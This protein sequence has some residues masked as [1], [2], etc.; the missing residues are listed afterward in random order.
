MNSLKKKPSIIILSESWIQCEEEANLFLLPDYKIFVCVGRGNKCSGI[1]VY[2]RTTGFLSVCEVECILDGADSVLLDCKLSN[3]SKFSLLC[4]YRWQGLANIFLDSLLKIFDS[5]QFKNLVVVG[6]VNINLQSD[7]LLVDEYLR[8]ISMYG[9]ESL[10]NISTRIDPISNKGT[11]IDHVLVNIPSFEIGKCSVVET[12]ITDHRATCVSLKLYSLQKSSTRNGYIIDF[13]TLSRLL[14]RVDWSEITQL[15]CVND[16]YDE[17]L[18]KLSDIV[19]L[20]KVDATKIINKQKVKKI[21]PWMTD[22]LCLAVRNKEKMYKRLKRLSGSNGALQKDFSKFKKKVDKWIKEAKARYYSNV[23]DN[24]ANN[25]KKQW[26]VINSLTGRTTHDTKINL[27]VNKSLIIDEK[28][29]SEHFNSYFVQIP[30]VLSSSIEKLEREQVNEYLNKFKKNERVLTQSMFLSPVSYD[31]VLSLI[32]KLEVSKSAGDDNISSK[33]VKMIGSQIAPVLVHIFNKSLETG[34]FPNKMKIAKVIPIHKSGSNTILNNYRPISLLSVFSKLLEK[35]VKKRLLSFLNFHNILS[36]FQFGFR[37]ELNTE[38]ALH[39]FMSNIYSSLNNNKGIKVSGLFLDIQ[40]AFDTVNHNLL[41]EKMGRVGMR[42]NVLNWFKSYLNNRSQYVQIGLANSALR[43]I[44][45]G[46]PQGSVLGPILFLIF[47]NDLFS[48]P[49]I[50]SITA[51]ADDTAFSYYSASIDHLYKNMQH[52][53]NYL[54]LW[55]DFNELSLHTGKTTFL[56]FSYFA[57]HSF[58][59]VLRYH[60]VACSRINCSCS[61]INRSESVKYLGVN[62]DDRL[63]WKTHVSNLKKHLFAFLRKFYVLKE[64]CPKL[65][66]RQIYFAFVN[67]KM[68]YGLSIWGSSFVSHFKPIITIQKAFVRLIHKKSM[69]SSSL[70]LFVKLKVLPFRHLFV[71]KVLDLFYRLSGNRGPTHNHNIVSYTTRQVSSSLLKFP[72]SFNSSFQKTFVFLG[73]KFYNTLPNSIKV[74]SS[75]NSFKK[76]L[77]QWLYTLSYPQLELMFQI[78]N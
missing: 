34:I 52:D 13:E 42:G 65:V 12:L 30:H 53:L 14:N 49:F 70:P 29:I 74:S 6:D 36:D 43:E 33:V 56:I 55:F 24:K 1:I 3:N 50:G 61:V 59:R 10:I 41:L 9:L 60:K 2:V 38:M 68:Q 75:L 45:C 69:F 32:N 76:N 40:K 39:N 48:G 22:G 7:D 4:L 28:L 26:Q 46:V 37:E 51:F 25:L 8:I 5:G 27:E 71:F 63:S 23:F 67:S 21:K 20:S 77:K 19:E 64:I 73:P 62:L 58:D 57:G 78:L 47:I 17:F 54:K 44:T 31:E 15:Q 66:L 35:I 72:K 16:L 11:I 18:F